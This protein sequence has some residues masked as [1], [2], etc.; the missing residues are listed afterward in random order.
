MNILSKTSYLKLHYLATIIEIRS[1]L[2]V[3]GLCSGRRC[4]EKNRDNVMEIFRLVDNLNVK[5]M[6]RLKRYSLK[7]NNFR[8]G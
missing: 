8:K 2:N 6:D 7:H 4:V 3:L 1:T 5:D